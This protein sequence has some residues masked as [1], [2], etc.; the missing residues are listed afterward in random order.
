MEAGRK[1][2]AFPAVANAADEVAVQRFL[3]GEIPFT[4]I[5]EILKAA[6][7]AHK[8]VVRP[9]LEAILEADRWA[10]EYARHV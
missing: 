7:E 1:G 9:V 2:G 8:S 5:P 10:R 4:R 3:K 6:L